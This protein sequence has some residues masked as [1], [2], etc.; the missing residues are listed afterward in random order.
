MRPIL[1]AV[2]VTLIALTI[3]MA[4]GLEDDRPLYAVCQDHGYSTTDSGLAACAD[5]LGLPCG[6]PYT[7]HL[8][9]GCEPEI[10][11]ALTCEL[12]AGTV[13]CWESP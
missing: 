2:A 5:Y 1:I 4:V 12:Y 6:D 3:S 10:G 7:D 13:E 9:P 8:R 11:T